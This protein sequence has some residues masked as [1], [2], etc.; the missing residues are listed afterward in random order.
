MVF[1]LPLRQSRYLYWLRY[2]QLGCAVLALWHVHWPLTVRVAALLLIMLYARRTRPLPE[3]LLFDSHGLQLC[4]A[5]R[6]SRARLGAQCYCTEFLV[7]LSV[8]LES[9]QPEDEVWGRAVVRRWLVLL[10]DSSSPDALRR[11][12]VYLR[13]HAQT[14]A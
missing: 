10:P 12:R 8:E 4:Y 2:L 13:W 9:D 7:V 6:R 14:P 3:A 11:L 1:W 5:W